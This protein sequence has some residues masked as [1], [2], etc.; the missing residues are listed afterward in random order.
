MTLSATKQAPNKHEIP[1]CEHF[2]NDTQNIA[3]SS[4]LLLVWFIVTVDKINVLSYSSSIENY[5]QALK[6][7]I[8][9]TFS[10]LF[11]YNDEET[12][13]NYR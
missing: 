6:A 5:K 7:S 9:P 11:V 13:K 2:M 8:N 3:I 12:M 10:T 4:Y 1:I